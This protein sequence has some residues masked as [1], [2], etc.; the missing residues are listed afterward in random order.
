MRKTMSNLLNDDPERHAPCIAATALPR[1]LPGTRIETFDAHVATFGWRPLGCASL[2][3]EVERAGL[4]GHGGASFPTATKMR[5]V[6]GRRRPGV[7]VVNATEGE[8]MSAKDKM[9]C[10][11]TPHLVLDGAALAAESVGATEVIVCIDRNTTRSIHSLQRAMEQRAALAH[12]PVPLRLETSPS[13]YI[14]GEES[15]LARWLNGGEAKPTFVP[16]RPFERG[17]ASRPTLVQNAETLAHVALIG[18][19]GAQWFRTLGTDEGPG[20]TLVTLSG[21]VARPG[22]YEIPVGL[23]IATL[24]AAAGSA[25]EETSALLIGGYFGTWVPADVAHGL[26][27]DPS[28][29]R[30]EGASLGCGVLVALPHDTCGLG[31]SAAVTAWLATQNAGQCGPCVNGLPTI[32]R[33]MQMLV[34][35]DPDGAVEAQ[36]QRWIEMVHGQRRLQA[37]GR[38]GALRGLDPRRICRRDRGPP[39]ARRVRR[40]ASCTRVLDPYSRRM[41]MRT[42][43]VVN[44]TMCVGHGMCAELL[45]ELIRLDDWGYPIVDP[46]P[47]PPSLEAHVRRTIDACPTLAVLRRTASTDRVH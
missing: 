43:L 37:S 25:V 14:A 19:F 11:V 4:R 20:S 23:P 24:L 6:A 31:E 42:R 21:A 44:W 8:P 17:V 39:A 27:L 18:R 12:D 40:N 3:S 22:V 34:A 36:I 46:R 41:A 10:W 33:G 7:V 45:P 26:T 35:G 29:L 28:S 16:P 47:I 15:A 9:L 32:A 1:I 2:I 13:R 5:A 30:T 38:R